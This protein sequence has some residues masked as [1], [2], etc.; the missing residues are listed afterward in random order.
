MKE[1]TPQEPSTQ[2]QQEIYKTD[3]ERGMDRLRQQL[4]NPQKIDLSRIPKR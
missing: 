3:T 4:Q 1:E 2:N